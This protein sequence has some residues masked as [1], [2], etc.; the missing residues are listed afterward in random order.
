MSEKPC[1]GCGSSGFSPS[2]LGEGR[3]TFCDGTEGGNPPTKNLY[4]VG[5]LEC[6]QKY[7]EAYSKEEALKKCR[8]FC[9]VWVRTAT[10]DEI[11]NHTPEVM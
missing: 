9:P 1:P 5:N 3:C 8:P 7:I 10:M 2:V 6:P 4:V 11:T